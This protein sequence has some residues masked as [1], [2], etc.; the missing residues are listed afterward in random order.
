MIIS[1]PENIKNKDEYHTPKIK[2]NFWSYIFGV[3]IFF[4]IKLMCLIINTFR[5]INK[6]E[7]QKIVYKSSISFIKI[8]ESCGCKLHIS[9]MSNLDL[10]ENQVIF[11]SNHMST[12]D[13]FILPGILFNKKTST[14]IVKKELQGVPFFNRILDSLNPIVIDKKSPKDDFI[15]IIKDSKE[16]IKNGKSIIVFPQGTRTTEFDSKKFNT[17]GIKLAKH[18]GIPILPI[19]LKTDFWTN[20]K[21]IKEIGKIDIN[22]EIYIEIGKP[23]YVKNN[24]QDAIYNKQITDFISTKLKE[25]NN[26]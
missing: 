3:N 17:I 14:F 25:W 8:A 2:R 5:K 23:I 9:G 24:G 1:F 18:T 26:K 4:F 21:L 16:V 20:G 15:K 12:F 6:K 19:A 13:I 22:K 7:S 10:V 11:T